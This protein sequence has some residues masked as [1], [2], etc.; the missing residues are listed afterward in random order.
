MAAFPTTATLPKE[1]TQAS[2]FL[3]HFP[4]FDGRGTVIAILDTGVDPGAVGMQVTTTGEPKVIEIIDCTG[5]GDV[6][7]RAEVEPHQDGSVK[8]LSGRTLTIPSEWPN[9]QTGKYRVGVKLAKGLFPKDLETP[10][11]KERKR[12]LEIRNHALITEV[13]AKLKDHETR[14]PK[15]EPTDKEYQV[16]QDLKDRVEVLKDQ[17]A[18]FDDPGHVF[19]VISFHD[20]TKWRAAIDVNET[21]DFKG[22]DLLAGYSDELKYSSFGDDSHLNFSINFYDDGDLLSIVTLSGTHGTHVAAI[23]AANH[24]T[25]PRQNGVAP[26]AKI[27][28]L[29]IGDSRL[30]SQETPQSLSRAAAELARL[31]CDVANISYGEPGAT[32]DYGRCIE[33]LREDAINKAGVIVVSAAGN[34]GPMLSSIG[35]PSGN[36]GLITV[37]AYLTQQMPGALYALLENVPE[38]PFSFTSLGPTLDGAVGVDVYAPGGAITSVPN[39]TKN[40]VQL[41]NGTS[42]ASPNA[43]GCVSL[44]VSGLKQ[45]RIPY[46]PYRVGIAVRNTSKQI[47]D[48]FQT[49]LI[50]VLQAWEHLS[51]ASMRH[52]VDVLYEIRVSGANRGRGLYLRNP[53]ETNTIQRPMVTVKPLFMNPD[54]PE[55]TAKR[56]EYE[57][58]VRLEA[59]MPWIQCPDFVLL[60]SEGRTFAINADPTGLAAGL[61]TGFVSGYDVNLPAAG[62]LFRVPVTVCKAG[63][64]E[65]DGALV[66]YKDVEFT[67]GKIE[68]K[69][70]P[71]PSGANYATVTVRSKERVG[72]AAFWIN[73]Q[74]IHAQTPYSAFESGM[75]LQLGSTTSGVEGE[76]FVKS[77]SFPVVP[78][79]T[80]EFVMCQYC[81]ALGTTVVSV[82]V[83]FHGIQVS[84]SSVV[85][86]QFGTKSSG[87][88]IFLNSAN[89]GLTRCDILSHLRTESISAVSVSLDK[90]QKSLRPTEAAIAPLKV[91]D[92][93]PDGRQ[94]YE[95]VLTYSLK[96]A[97]DG[98]VL[99][100]YPRTMAS[101]YD[102]FFES[103]FIFVYDT[104][105]SLKSVHDC[106]SRPVKLK[107]GTYTAKMQIVSR[108]LEVLDKLQQTPILVDLDT[109]AV[110]L[111]SYKSLGSL[112]AGTDK[113]TATTLARGETATF[114]LSGME[115]SALPKGAL[116]G[117][118]LL[119]SFK[120]SDIG[121]SKIQAAYLVPSELPKKEDAASQPSIPVLP[122]TAE[123][124]KKDELAEAIRDL[125]IAHLKKLG[126][127]LVKRDA[128]MAKL[129]AEHGSH[130]P[131]LLARLAVYTTEFD[132]AH[133]MS[134]VTPDHVQNVEKALDTILAA[135]D[136]TEVAVYFGLKVD[137]AAGGEAAKAKQKDME[138][139]KTA[140]AQVL[141]WRARLLKHKIVSN[142]DADA[143]TVSTGAFDQ[144]LVDASRWIASPPTTDGKYLVL[145]T[146][147]LKSQGMLGS[148]LKSINKYLSDAKNVASGDAEKT[149]IW[150]ELT[151]VKKE[152]VAELGWTVWAEHELRV[153]F[154]RA[155]P[156]YVPF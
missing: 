49:G 100:Y 75:Y 141:L 28:S 9:P 21:G 72:N 23:A 24:P 59:S 66:R 101:F 25:D 149:A 156:A 48:P 89:A 111:T 12:K 15:L 115:G 132:K 142:A 54:D 2:A 120:V 68:R 57:A 43:C 61:H 32:F 99:P 91:R 19:D 97:E 33:I 50:Q 143:A 80:A 83:E 42:M 138:T 110:T 139:R 81:T 6:D 40:T 29:K 55:T 96:V 73:I 11:M 106:K 119:G 62:P 90:V 117:D 86:G 113:F 46:N 93:L 5:S 58:H 35:H 105:K 92:L 133:E 47:G 102:S 123:S 154:V 34:S 17:F 4:T 65:S 144:A 52:N 78:G 107:E 69:F 150:K 95:L 26:G 41:M 121:A 112:I 45:S 27:I 134:S 82:D 7:M 71:V 131:F 20:G 146:W 63:Q 148:A 18:S 79:F 77:Q 31:K 155:P 151:A 126:D 22:T 152:I 3:D 87:D 64:A 118:L 1:E 128:L 124:V 36:S 136:Q 30:G 125:E 98:N 127:D 39:Y 16:R 84:A 70:I 122:S 51:L 44:L 135:V 14:F 13:Q 130:L 108:S 8:G 104:Q 10:V 116:P 37:G 129:T 153:A 109:K 38:R 56:L 140:V 74:Q 76:E 114:W 94:L 85:E 67:S 147:R 53:V 145:W 137:L 103:V 88:M 60:A